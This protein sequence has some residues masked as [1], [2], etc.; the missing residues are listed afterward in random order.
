MY[1]QTS[2]FSSEDN[3]GHPISF[4]WINKEIGH[5]NIFLNKLWKYLMA[6]CHINIV[7]TNGMSYASQLL[8]PKNRFEDFLLLIF[9]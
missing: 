2:Q 7:L 5:G 9:L 8:A 3:V 6:C 4:R 1:G